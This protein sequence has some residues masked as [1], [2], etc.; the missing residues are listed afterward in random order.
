M[1][2]TY[3]NISDVYSAFMSP[4]GIYL[5]LPVPI[6]TFLY[7]VGMECDELCVKDPGKFKECMF[8]QYGKCNRQIDRACACRFGYI[9]R[10]KL[11]IDNI[12]KILRRY[13]ITIFSSK[14]KATEAGKKLQVERI[15]TMRDKGYN[16]DENTGKLI[17]NREV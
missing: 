5:K 8:R 15:K 16:I 7:E 14:E 10:V 13:E 11:D 6:D 1:E 9:Q 2:K 4:D 3:R 12:A 17:E